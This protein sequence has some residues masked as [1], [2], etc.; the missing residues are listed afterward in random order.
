MCFSFFSKGQ[1]GWQNARA[2]VR[3]K[4]MSDSVDGSHV[5]PCFRFFSFRFVFLWFRLRQLIFII[6]GCRLAT[7]AACMC[8]ERTSIALR[9]Q[10]PKY[11]RKYLKIGEQQ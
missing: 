4:P 2:M 6:A 10:S 1:P 5:T 8:L 3:H 11:I 7:M 9:F